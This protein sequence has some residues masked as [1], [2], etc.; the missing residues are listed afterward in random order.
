MSGSELGLSLDGCYG[1]VPYEND[2]TDD[3]AASKERKALGETR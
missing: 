3:E 2:D 1:N